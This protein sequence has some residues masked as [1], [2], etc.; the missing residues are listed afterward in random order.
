MTKPIDKSFPNGARTDAGDI[1]LGS[2][3]HYTKISAE[4]HQTMV[5][6][7]RPWRDEKNDT[8]GLKVQG[9]GISIDPDEVTAVYATTADYPTDFQYVNVQLNHDRDLSTS[10]YPH[11]HWFQAAKESPN[12]L[13]A[14]RWQIN[15]GEKVTDWTPLMCNSLVFT[16]TE[17]T[18]HQISYAK[19]ISSETN[20]SDVVQ[21]K[22][23]R[24]TANDSG[25][26]GDLDP[27]DADV[28]V[29]SFDCHVEIN[30]LGS[31]TEY[32]KT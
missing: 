21:F 6:D 11:I 15:G 30:S 28:H 17:G 27:Y 10:I 18:I 12:F 1:Y 4:G 13:L 19:P 14:Y 26:F 7:A 32:S 29:L 5:G 3:S 8:I 25:L 9:T 2:I 31:N 20:I 23:Y 22:I 16:Y 24:D